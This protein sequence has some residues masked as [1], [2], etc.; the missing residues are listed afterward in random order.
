MVLITILGLGLRLIGINKTQGLWN[1]EYVSWFV[2]SHPFGQ[3]F[4]KEIFLQCHMPFYYL[5]LKFFMFFGGDSD[6]FLRLTSVFAG[7]LSIIVM[8]FVGLQNNRKTGLLCALFASLSSF[9]IYYSQEV[10]LYS[11]LFLISA[12]SLLYLLKFLKNKN[13][14]NL[15]GLILFDF[16]IVFTHTIGFVYVFFQLIAIT[17]L[18]YKEYKKQLLSLWGG[19]VLLSLLCV[20]Q[21][22]KIL[23]TQTFSQWWGH[24]SISKIGFLFTDYFSPVLTNLVNAPDKFL[25]VKSFS[26]VLFTI[27]PALIAV[28]F[29]IKALWKNKENLALVG[30]VFGVVVVMVV[31]AMM[32][33]LVF[34][35]KYSIEIYPILI[36]LTVFGACSIK[37]KLFSLVPVIVFCLINLVYIITSPVSA[38]KMPRLQGHKIVAELLTRAEPNEGDY[39]LLEY[40]PQ[41]RYE[42]YFDFSK[43]NIVSVNKGNFSK[44]I[45]PDNSY[46]QIYKDGKNLYRDVFSGKKVAYIN[47]K[48]NEDIMKNLKPGKQVFVIMADSVSIYSPTDIEYI[49]SND[50]LY[51]NTPLMYM[52][53]SYVKNQVFMNLSGTL[54]VTRYEKLGDWSLV[55]FTK[56]NN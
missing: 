36:Y 28:G 20:P 5:Y 44:Y 48:I 2:A 15:G 26:F 7:V 6:V 56:L 1:D 51:E 39:I 14:T 29:I 50:V 49:A 38:P 22:V 3:S 16:L 31:A 37:K 34:I 54:S 9:L 21:I 17:Y 32:G 18:L 27:V 46:S 40:Y 8:Y 41:N 4:F 13:L 42:K 24:F 30:I 52:V 33:K 53:F 19:V 45:A 47:Y 55:R 35:T 23:T 11:L 25:Y 12:I 10:R 43:Y